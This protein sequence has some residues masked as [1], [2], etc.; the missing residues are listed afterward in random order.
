MRY[1]KKFEFEL[2]KGIKIWMMTPE[3]VSEIMPLEAD[4]FDLLIF[5]EASQI[6]VEKGIPAIARAKKVLIVGDH[7]QLRPSGLG[8][9]RADFA[10]EESEEAEESEGLAALEEESLLDLARF[11]FPSVV[12]DYHYRSKYEE[13]I[14]FSNYAFYKGR[15]H[16]SP[17]VSPPEKPPIEVIKVEDGKWIDRTNL[18]EAERVVRLLKDFFASRKKAQTVGII[19]FNS[20]QRDLVMDLLDRE[21]RTDPA[22]SDALKRETERKENG[23]DIGL[24]VKNIENVQGDERDCIIFSIAYAKNESGKVVRNFGW[25]NQRGGENRLNVAISRAKEKIYIVTSIE[26]F[27]LSVGDLANNGPKLFKKYLEYACAV[28]RG[29]KAAAR[30]ILIGL[31][32]ETTEA[33]I[34]TADTE[35]EDAVYESLAGAGYEVE[36]GIG[37]GGYRI[38]LAVKKDGKYLLGIECDG[39]LYIGSDSTRE[40]D[41]HRQKYLESRGWSIYRLRANRW[42]RDPKG[43]IARIAKQLKAK[44]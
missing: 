36:R 24:F 28:S 39:K 26:P 18:A 10:E 6:Y 23:E 2:F 4:L 31:C 27:E 19:T 5:D 43:E 42:W 33:D 37:I 16:V 32:G 12:L 38:D 3:V 9:G 30:T 13:L 11:K 8:I 21:G 40:R 22:F 44:N 35:F 7:K 17:N 14:A 34:S 20:Y 41:V 25:L 1:V 29:D 15:L